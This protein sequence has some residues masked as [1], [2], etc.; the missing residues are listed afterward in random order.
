MHSIGGETTGSKYANLQAPA[1]SR[2]KNM[3][4]CTTSD[5]HQAAF[6]INEYAGIGEQSF[7][8]FSQNFFVLYYFF[9]GDNVR[10]LFCRSSD[11]Y[12]VSESI[13]RDRMEYIDVSSVLIRASL[14]QR[15]DDFIEGNSTLEQS[16]WK[17]YPVGN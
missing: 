4:A 2:C 7:P 11:N 16:K 9:F 13:V 10:V 5:F 3:T 8:P 12:G 15:S 1:F 14:S 17:N 6:L